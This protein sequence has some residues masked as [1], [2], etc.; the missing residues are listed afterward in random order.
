MKLDSGFFLIPPDLND[1]S[2]VYD[3]ARM[4]YLSQQI[5]ISRTGPVFYIQRSK[6]ATTRHL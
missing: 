6:E 4:K 3:S 1:I 2:N 5:Q